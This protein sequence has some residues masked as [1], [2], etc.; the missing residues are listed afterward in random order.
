MYYDIP[1]GFGLRKTAND[2]EQFNNMTRDDVI[3]TIRKAG[4]RAKA[5]T[6]A[7]DAALDAHVQARRKAID[8]LPAFAQPKARALSDALEEKE[9]ANAQLASLGFND[10]SDLVR[11]QQGAANLSKLTGY[12][13]A[14][15]GG[16]LLGA[17]LAGK[18]RRLLGALAGAGAGLLGNYI[19]R[20]SYYGDLV[21]Y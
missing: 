13:L 5:K 12:G 16:G 11:E 10:L 17:Y 15:G 3:D 18:E 19:R 4:L 9:R 2:L 1:E 21:N 8:K 7:L 14:A 6:H 20:K